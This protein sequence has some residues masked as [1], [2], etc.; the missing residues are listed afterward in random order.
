M[1]TR[2]H[3]LTKN[4]RVKLLYRQLRKLDEKF[5]LT[6]SIRKIRID[7][8][9]D[10]PG[11]S[12]ETAVGVAL[13]DTSKEYTGPDY[14]FHP[15]KVF[16]HKKKVGKEIKLTWTQAI[17]EIFHFLAK[18]PNMPFMPE[19]FQQVRKTALEIAKMKTKK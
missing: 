17:K 8:F 7:Y 10:D 16:S 6:D 12:G 4:Q 19:L 9:A 18:Q 13:F 5:S 11:H 2:M 14:F 15:D 3:D 1:T